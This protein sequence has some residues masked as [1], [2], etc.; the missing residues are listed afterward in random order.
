MPAAAAAASWL[1]P[2][3]RFAINKLRWWLGGGAGIPWALRIGTRISTTHPT[4]QRACR[5]PVNFIVAGQPPHGA[6]RS[7][8]VMVRQSRS[9]SLRWWLANRIAACRLSTF[10]PVC[11]PKAMR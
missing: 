8:R 6:S 4:G 2:P 10:K 3:R 5:R 11:G 9:S 7:G 1:L